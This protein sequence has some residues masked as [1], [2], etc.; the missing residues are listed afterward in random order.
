MACRK[1]PV[2]SQLPV[3]SRPPARARPLS[4]DKCEL[5]TGFTLV[6]MLVTLTLVSVIMA[7]VYGSYAAASRCVQFHDNRA[8]SLERACLVLRLLGRQL[9]CAYVPT[10]ATGSSG[11]SA[12]SGPVPIPAPAFRADPQDA[13]G[14][15][16]SFLT[17]GGLGTGANTAAAPTHVL[18]RYD[19]RSGTLSLATEPS[20]RLAGLPETREGRTILRGVRSVQVHC[21]DGQRWRP[22]WDGTERGRLPRAVRIGFT[23]RDERGRE[24]EFGTAIPIGCRYAP[25]QRA[26]VVGAA[27]P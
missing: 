4:T 17:T 11:P 5:S 18:Y 8:A 7:I 15:I 19:A 3:H 9:R 26:S 27:Q 13:D 25:P 14:R 1:Q 24:H 12:S 23:V 20:V 16:L 10:T 6:E 22:A 21:Y 2:R